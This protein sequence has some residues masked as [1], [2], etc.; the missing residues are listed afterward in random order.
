[1]QENL[2][3]VTRLTWTKGTES[4]A[5]GFAV[6]L[7]FTL[8]ESISRHKTHLQTSPHLNECLWFMILKSKSLK[9]QLYFLL[10]NSMGRLQN[11]IVQKYSSWDTLWEVSLGL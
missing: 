8:V 11:Q 6:A 1:M 10:V 2:Q 3:S 5:V 7:R 9:H 4:I